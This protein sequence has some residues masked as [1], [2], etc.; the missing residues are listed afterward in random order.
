MGWNP[1]RVL[2]ARTHLELGWS[3][4]NVGRGR[5]EQLAGGR[6]RITLQADLGRRLR[7]QVLGHELVHDELDLLWPPDAP[8]PLVEKGER[9]VER[10]NAERTIPI[11]AL[12]GFVRRRVDS[13]LPVT[14]LDV[15]EEFDV[16][17]ELA[18]LAL[19][20]IAPEVT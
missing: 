5:I 4:F 8:L 12:E 3:W 14:A 20:L 10:I 19:T 7:S 15:A 17:E 2:R 6:R 9:L 11:G 16:T 18:G 13:D 1:W